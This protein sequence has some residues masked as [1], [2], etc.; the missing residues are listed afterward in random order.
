VPID[1]LQTRVAVL[2]GDLQRSAAVQTG[3][4]CPQVRPEWL[5]ECRQQGRA[6]APEAFPA[7][8]PPSSP[9]RSLAPSRSEPQCDSVAWDN[10]TKAKLDRAVERKGQI[11]AASNGG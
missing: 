1:C 6:V 7:D 2:A 8:L 11:D 9:R 3:C 10:D 5:R 4:R